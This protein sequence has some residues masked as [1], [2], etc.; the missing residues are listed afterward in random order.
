MSRHKAK[1]SNKPSRDA[2][3]G[4]FVITALEDE[5]WDYRTAEGI[6]RQISRPVQEVKVVLETDPRVRQSVMKA[7]SGAGLYTLKK[8]RSALKDIFTAFRA[9]N[10]DKLGDDQ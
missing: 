2:S 5:K 3:T 10:S 4:S 8:K 9:M 6:A 7:W 1:R